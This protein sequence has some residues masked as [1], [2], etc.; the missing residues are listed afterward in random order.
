[1]SERLGRRSSTVV[2]DVTTLL[3]RHE[4][5][6]DDLGSLLSDT[7]EDG[8]LDLVVTGE[9]DG[10]ED[11][12]LAPLVELCGGKARV[13]GAEGEEKGERSAVAEGKRACR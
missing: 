5:P 1:L 11:E 9:D 6:R 3:L 4:E 7:S 10:G 2:A 12:K 8:R 13:D